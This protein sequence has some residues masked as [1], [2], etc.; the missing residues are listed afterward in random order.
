MST[1]TSNTALARSLFEA[2]RFAPQG[3]PDPLGPSGYHPRRRL[4]SPA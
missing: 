4:R 3:R 2:E 1:D